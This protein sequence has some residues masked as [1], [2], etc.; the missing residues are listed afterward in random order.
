MTSFRIS[1]GILIALILISVWYYSAV[2]TTIH[3]LEDQTSALGEAIEAQD[4]NKAMAEYMAFEGLLQEKKWLLLA[5]ADHGRLDQIDAQVRRLRTLVAKMESP[6][7][8]SEN[9]VLRGLILNIHKK[10]KV[11]WENFF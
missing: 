11:I 4:T 8:T 1:I 6:Q 2:H 3:A 7:A 10:E 9:D 5:F